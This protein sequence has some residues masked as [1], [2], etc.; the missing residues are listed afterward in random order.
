MY[1]WYFEI[2]IGKKYM[3]ITIYPNSDKSYINTPFDKIIF[4]LGYPENHRYLLR[5]EDK[6]KQLIKSAISHR[7]ICVH[8]DKNRKINHII[9]AKDI[10]SFFNGPEDS[11]RP[12]Y[13]DDPVDIRIIPSLRLINSIM[14]NILLTQ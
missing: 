5:P 2:I 8:P 7:V 12:I 10:N 13:D 6:I 4:S 14:A 3:Y 1:A 11:N 9:D